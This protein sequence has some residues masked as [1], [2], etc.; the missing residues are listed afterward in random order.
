M[1][2][3]SCRNGSGVEWGHRRWKQDY[4]ELIR[5]QMGWSQNTT[6]WFAHGLVLWATRKCRSNIQGGSLIQTL[7]LLT[8]GQSLSF[9]Q[10]HPFMCAEGI[11]LSLQLRCSLGKLT[12]VFKALLIRT[13]PCKKKLAY[14]FNV[15]VGYRGSIVSWKRC[16]PRRGAI[17]F[18]SWSAMFSITALNTSQ[19]CLNVCPNM[20]G[21]GN[22]HTKWS[23]SDR[24]RQISYDTTYLWNLKKNDINELIYKTNRSTDIKNKLTVTKGQKQ[25]EGSKLGTW[26]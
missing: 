12:N 22:D 2:P 20:D 7:F 8:C 6:S 14:P 15:T 24:E 5:V 13:T 1:E 9:A 26:E 3:A 10:T 16:C 11:N 21:P 4:E 25:E 17:R 18:Q 23:E 19:E